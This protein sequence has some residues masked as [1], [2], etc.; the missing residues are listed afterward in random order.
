LFGDYGAKQMNLKAALKYQQLGFSVIPV[1]KDKKPFIKWERYQS[2]KADSDQLRAWWEKWPNGNIGLV[3]GEVSGIDVVDCD[4]EKGRDALNEFLSDSHIMPISKTPKGWHY[5]FKHSPGLSNGVR[6]IADCDLRTTGGYI[7]V[8]PSKNGEGKPYAWMQDLKI[9]DV[10]PARMPKMLFEILQSGGASKALNKKNAVLSTPDLRSQYSVL[11]MG[12]RNISF[13]EPG[14]DETLFHIAN[15]LFKG[16][17]AKDNILKCLHFIGSN[18]N[19][20]F[21]KRDVSAKI[22]SALKRAEK[23]KVSL[24]QEVR[25]FV[26]ST[27]GHIMSTEIFNCLHLSTRQEKKNVSMALARLIDEGIIERTGN[28][29]GQFRRIESE[30][31]PID[32]LNADTETV[33]LWFPFGLHEKAEVMPG[34]IIVV[35]G[36][37]DA[38]KTA[39]LLNVIRA[40]P[41]WGRSPFIDILQLDTWKEKISL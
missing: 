21:K 27:S 11:S 24:T 35:A 22:K 9:T 4:S 5:F 17:M 25:E 16:G 41:D 18:C 15:C 29:N 39:F 7:I 30:A 3:T 40:E 36:S 19:P 6:V 1:R 2:E 14:R 32:F 28:R 13:D 26:L 10:S 12:G 34:N 33:D 8:P 31:E 20:P 23:Q 38:G 37:P